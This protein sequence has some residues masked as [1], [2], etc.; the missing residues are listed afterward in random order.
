VARIET[1]LRHREVTLE[2]TTAAKDYLVAKGFDPVLGAR[3]LRRVVQREL[4]DALSEQI[5]LDGLR[6]GQV[7][8]V[9]VDGGAL[10]F[11]TSEAVP[12]G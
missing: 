12:I 11:R 3:P 8:V 4:E 10:T 2:L 7:V 9:D 6:P 5:L 1:Q